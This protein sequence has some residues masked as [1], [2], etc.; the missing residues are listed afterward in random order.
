MR[1]VHIVTGHPT[2]TSGELL[3]W[4]DDQVSFDSASAGQRLE[5]IKRLDPHGEPGRRYYVRSP[6]VETRGTAEVALHHALQGL[7]AAHEREMK[8]EAQERER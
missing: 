2:D 4:I 6:R 7:T 3:D 1:D 8:R 5:E